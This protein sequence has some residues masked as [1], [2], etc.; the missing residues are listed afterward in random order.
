MGAREREAWQPR[1]MSRPIFVVDAFTSEPFRGNPAAVVLDH[2]DDRWM[3]RVAA[4][5]RHS[6][7]AFVRARTGG[8]F[9]LRWFS[10]EVEVDLC[11]HAT[12]AAAHVLF[13]TGRVGPGTTARF[14]TRGG[15]LR[16]DPAGAEGIML[17]FPVAEPVPTPAHPELLDALGLRSG[18]VLRTDGEFFMCVVDDAST[19]RELAPDLGKLR[20]LSGVRGVYVTAPGDA[21]YDIVSRC[22]APRIGIDEDPVTGSMYCVLVAYWGTRL[23]KDQLRGF[24]ASQRGGEVTVVRKGDRA[25]LT[26]R[27]SIVL[28][29]ELRA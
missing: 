14:H 4:E 12:L 27:A 8:G 26:G 5:M 11:G 3:Q 15:E 28:A 20:A 13:E 22:F 19:V 17:D 16:A 29:G 21:G 10:P 24:Q 7:T 6:E 25:L 1:A 18:E 2:G 23:G 9:D